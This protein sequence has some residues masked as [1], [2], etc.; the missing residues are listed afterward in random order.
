MKGKGTIE[1][2]YYHEATACVRIN[3]PTRPVLFY[4]KEG[5]LLLLSSLF[6]DI[7]LGGLTTVPA[8]LSDNIV[9]LIN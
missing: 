6:L 7:T 9:D 8:I 3:T 2:Y 1:M 5:V 4:Y